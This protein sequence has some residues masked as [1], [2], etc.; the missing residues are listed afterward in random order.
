[1]KV[2]IRSKDGFKVVDLNRRKAINERCKNCSCWVSGE[3]TN[4]SFTD[5]PLYPYRSIRGKQ[6][7]KARAKSIRRYCLWCMAGQRSEVKKCVSTTCPL[8]SYRLKD[9]D[10][11]VEIVSKDEN[12]RIEPV[13]EANDNEKMLADSE[14][15]KSALLG[16]I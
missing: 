9:I 8:F 11:S 7:A 4:C 6:N 16:A 2:Q 15:K 3:V 13:S 1:M 5:C 10:R 12:A 14:D